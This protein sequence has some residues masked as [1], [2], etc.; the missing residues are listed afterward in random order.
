LS[1]ISG[2]DGL[3]LS[4]KASKIKRWREY[5]EELLNRVPP[6]A[7]AGLDPVAVLHRG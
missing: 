4:D 1:P 2:T 3:L 7:V 6:P 5:Y